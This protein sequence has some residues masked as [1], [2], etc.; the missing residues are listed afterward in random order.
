MRTV[1]CSRT[2]FTAALTCLAGK[3]PPV[4]LTSLA[5]LVPAAW[6][7][8][9]FFWPSSVDAPLPRG[10]TSSLEPAL[11]PAFPLPLAPALPPPD[12]VPVEF[13]LAMP[14]SVSVRAAEVSDASRDALRF[15]FS[16]VIIRVISRFYLPGS[17][18]LQA[19]RRPPSWQQ[20]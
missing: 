15:C 12:V 18:A 20:Y 2:D 16:A 1:F 17:S 7:W 13:F 11:P 6:C 14:R 5:A 9:P 10:P 4:C 8:A 19:V 3:E